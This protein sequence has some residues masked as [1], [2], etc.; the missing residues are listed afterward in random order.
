M[1]RHGKIAPNKA[2]LSVNVEGEIKKALFE[3]AEREGRTLSNY[4]AWRLQQIVRQEK[5][6]GRASPEAS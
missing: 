2:L 5:L 4:V 1:S 3:L 6:K